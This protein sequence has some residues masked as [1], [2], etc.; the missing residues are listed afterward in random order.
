MAEEVARSRLRSAVQAWGAGREEGSSQAGPALVSGELRQRRGPSRPPPTRL[1]AL[2]LDSLRLPRDPHG[3]CP[4]HSRAHFAFVG[5]G[6]GGSAAPL[7]VPAVLGFSRLFAPAWLIAQARK[8]LA[9]GMWAVPPWATRRAHLLRHFA[10]QAAAAEGQL[11]EPRGPGLPRVASASSVSGSPG[12]L[13]TGALFQDCMAGPLQSPALRG[14][15]ALASQGTHF[16]KDK[17]SGG[18]RED[19]CSPPR[20]AGGGVSSAS[21]R[22]QYGFG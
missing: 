2:E 1:H 15:R 7:P 6:G 8:G 14:G 18:H 20:L 16:F 22:F 13:A 10:S 21:Y 9:G 4:A 5:I 3:P 19:S 12:L 17:S 11:T